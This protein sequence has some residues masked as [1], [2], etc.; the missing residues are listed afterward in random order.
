MPVQTDTP[1]GIGATDAWGLWGSAP[2]KLA[3]V[4]GNDGDTSVVY[5][6]SGGALVIQLF[7]FP[8]LLGVAD[9][10]NAASLTAVTR[11]YLAGAGGRGYSLYWNSTQIAVNRA[12]EVDAVKPAY[13]AVTYNAAGANLVLATVNGQHG[14]GFTAAGGPSNKAEYWVTHVYRTVDFTYASGSSL[15]FAH[16][17]GSLAA[18]VIGSGLLLS[19]M[20]HLSRYMG[21]TRGVWLLPEELEPAWRAWHAQ[22]RAAY[23]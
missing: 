8:P 1:S 16:L 22:K 10:V 17:I 5:A 7:S 18:G 15:E 11:Q 13:L 9:P 3:A 6:A 12:A 23:A 20:P 4:A 19:E 21:R 14:M 2:S